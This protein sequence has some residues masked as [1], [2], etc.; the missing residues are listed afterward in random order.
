MLISTQD[1]SSRQLHDRDFS[2][3]DLNGANFDGAYLH[4][5]NFRGAN[6]RHASFKCADLRQVDFTDADLSG[7]DFTGSDLSEA[8]SG[9]RPFLFTTSARKYK[10]TVTY[11]TTESFYVEAVNSA[12]AERKVSEGDCAGLD[13]DCIFAREIRS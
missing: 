8:F 12:D 11:T 4:R 5:A 9:D 6:L 10:V 1:F 2:F 13:I 3:Q 7:A